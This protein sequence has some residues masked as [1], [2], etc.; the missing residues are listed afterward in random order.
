MNRVKLVV[1]EA[2]RSIGSN[3][4]TSFAATMTVL[5]GMFLLGLLIALGTWVVSW[6]EHVKDQ[7][8]VKVFFVDGVTPKQV[9]AVGAYLRTN[10]EKIADYQFVSRAEALQR[11]RKRYPE[12][13]ENLPTNPLPASYEITPQRAEEVKEIS[14]AIRCEVCWP[15]LTRSTP[16]NFCARI[17]AEISLTSS[18]RCGVISYDAGSGF[19]GRFS[20]SSG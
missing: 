15:S 12:L 17:A 9:N 19:V 8:E 18:A 1:S 13:T 20:V 5:I 6:S 11:M 10:P 14:S 3:L 2:L 4:S 16:A 7:L